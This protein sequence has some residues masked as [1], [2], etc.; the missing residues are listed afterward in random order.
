MKCYKPI[1]YHLLSTKMHFLNVYNCTI[2]DRWWQLV[3]LNDNIPQLREEGIILLA[4]I[5]V[6][7]VSLR[8]FWL[9]VF[10]SSYTLVP[11]TS[12]S[13]FKR[14]WS[15]AVASWFIYENIGLPIKNETAKCT[16]IKD[17]S[18]RKLKS[19]KHF[20]EL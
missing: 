7:P 3:V 13:S 5:S 20:T 2:V 15:L 16:A 19:Q 12:R 6:I 11:A 10:L 9:S 8:I 4:P 18:I 17:W 1:K 14:S